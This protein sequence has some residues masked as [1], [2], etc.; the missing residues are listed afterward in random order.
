MA[1]AELLRQLEALTALDPDAPAPAE[2]PPMPHAVELAVV[3][4][5]A[6]RA[7]FVDGSSAEA[8][9]TGF[10]HRRQALEPLRDP[11]VF[12]TARLADE[13]RA[14]RFRDDPELEIGVD[15][16]PAIAVRQAPMTGPDFAAWMQRHALSANGAADVLGLARRTVLA[17]KAA[18]VVPDIVKAACLAFDIDGTLLA[19]LHRPRRPGP[20]RQPTRSRNGSA[21]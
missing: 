15:L 19:A 5:H 1:R 10:V 6:L 13:G 8:D 18:T 9:L 7:R 2:S 17:Y 21:G 12:A 14:I 11:A 4:P 20:R 16:L 3:G